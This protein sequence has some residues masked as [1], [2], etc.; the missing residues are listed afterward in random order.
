MH[1]KYTKTD[2][3]LILALNMLVIL[4][5]TAI[6]GVLYQTDLTWILVFCPSIVF[7]VIVVFN[8]ILIKALKVE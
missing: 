1:N 4:L 8:V 2:K 5:L 7:F 3:V 6:V